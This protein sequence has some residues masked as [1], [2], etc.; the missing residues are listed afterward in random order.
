VDAV[1]AEPRRT[2]RPFGTLFA[3]TRL[4]QT[5]V[6]QVAVGVLEAQA[7]SQRGRR[8]GQL[9]S[10]HRNFARRLGHVEHAQVSGRRRAGGHSRHAVIC[11]PLLEV[12]A[13]CEAIFRAS[14]QVVPAHP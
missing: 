3:K 6:A 5:D 14:R 2:L 1:L 7:V 8:G 9:Q 13:E 10:A 11:F 4:L 12:L